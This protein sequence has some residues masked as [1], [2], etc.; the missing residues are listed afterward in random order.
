MEWKWLEN[1]LNLKVKKD[2]AGRVR[3]LSH[4]EANRLVNCC[5]EPLKSVVKFALCTGLRRSNIVNL[6]WSQVDLN[7]RVAWIHAENS[8]SGRAIGV[9]LNSIACE[10]LRNQVGNH[11][12]Y[13]FVHTKAK[14]R[15]DGSM[16]EPV[17]K[18]RVDDNTGF[19]N[20]LN[21]AGIENFRFH[22]L[23][24]TWASWL[25]QSGVP[26]S[27]LK[28]M[29]GWESLEMVF[30]YAHLAPEHLTA[31]AEHIDKIL[32]DRVSKTSHLKI[33]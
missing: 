13:V 9:P 12:L 6:E 22:D 3:W 16:T 30:R 15:A 7:R 1:P 14:N 18:M 31:H 10:I 5:S 21:R 24:H 23:R 27:D 2:R 28:T 4:E 26:L 33:A 20:A 11:H 25:I 19:R 29:G 17:R 32:G 8:K